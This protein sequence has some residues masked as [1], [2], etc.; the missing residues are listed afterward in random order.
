M[1]K[2]VSDI[3][4]KIDFKSPDTKFPVN[5]SLKY[6]YFILCRNRWIYRPDKYLQDKLKQHDFAD[7]KDMTGN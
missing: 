2:R 6:R 3:A 1:Y 7:F 5:V 4:K